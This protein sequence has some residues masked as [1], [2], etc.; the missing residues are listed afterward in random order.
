MARAVLITMVALAG[1]STT[2]HAPGTRLP[3]LHPL[4]RHEVRH[5]RQQMFNDGLVGREAGTCSAS[6][7]GLQ[8]CRWKQRQKAPPFSCHQRVGVPGRGG[9]ATLPLVMPN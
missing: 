9:R 4:D 7:G 3:C 1:C 6:V 5:P 8:H 2:V